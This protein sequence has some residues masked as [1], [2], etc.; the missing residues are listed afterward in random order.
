MI[1][2]KKTKIG[3]PKILAA[4]LVGLIDT[5]A[6]FCRIDVNVAEKY[7]LTKTQP[8]LSVTAG[9]S[10]STE[11][12]SGQLYFPAINFT[13]E[14]NRMPASKFTEGRA[15]FDIILGMDFLSRFD[16]RVRAK[17]NIVELELVDP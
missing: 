10:V 8:I 14:A 5:G 2:T 3:P 16:L 7:K 6:D 15:L 17:D 9:G 11:V 1:R 12:F 4:G 13:F